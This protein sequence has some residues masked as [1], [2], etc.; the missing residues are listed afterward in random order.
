MKVLKAMGWFSF[1]YVSRMI[2]II[3][4][5]KTIDIITDHDY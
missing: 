2:E 5:M 4:I 1:G 3:A